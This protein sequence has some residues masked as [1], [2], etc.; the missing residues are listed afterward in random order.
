MRDDGGAGMKAQ[1]EPGKTQRDDEQDHQRRRQ[2]V[3]QMRRREK[4]RAQQNAEDRLQRAAIKYLF[5]EKAGSKAN[6]SANVSEPEKA[7]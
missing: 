4:E 6:S 3:L 7:S 5:A 2:G 1:S